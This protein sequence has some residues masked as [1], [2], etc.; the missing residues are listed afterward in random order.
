MRAA[1][2]ERYGP[3]EVVTLEEIEKPVPHAG[4][5]LIKTRATTVTSGDCRVRS[6]NAPKGFGL[7]VRLVFGVF[8]PRQPILG[9]ELAGKIVAIGKNVTRFKVGDAV[10]GYSGFGMACHA[11][12]KCI[13]ED[14][15]VV[16]KPANLTDE[17]AAALSFGGTTVLDFFRRAKLQKSEKVLVIGASGCVGTAAVQLAKHFGAE[18]SGVCS[19]RNLELLKRLGAH[20][21]IDYTNNDLTQIS[22]D[23]D[24]IVDAVGAM[25]ISR[26]LKMLREKGRL[27][28]VVASLPDML[29]GLWW[30]LINNKKVIAGS[31]SEHPDDLR[32]LAELAQIGAFKPT[33]DRYYDFEQIAQAH[34]YVDTG[35]KRGNVVVT[36]KQ[37]Q[38]N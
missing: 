31:A 20:H 29:L 1:V 22:E 8:K 37:Q 15:M 11:E 9:T 35:R 26:K 38:I 36:F 6:L 23:Y 7:M 5:V 21:V 16:A 4:E 3:P 12:F 30:S 24:V 32:T 28:L 34:A 25:P 13:P 17:E 10:F 33:I 19:T 14:G 2:C 18:V 27:L